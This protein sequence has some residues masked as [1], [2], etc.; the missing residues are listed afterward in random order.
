MHASGEYTDHR[1][2]MLLAFGA[3]GRGFSR[4]R[5]HKATQ[6][7]QPWFTVFEVSQGPPWDQN[8]C[9]TEL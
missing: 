1:D 9:W 5:S 2:A 8:M 3:R 7:L 4:R 6:S